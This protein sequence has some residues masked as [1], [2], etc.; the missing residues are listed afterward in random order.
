MVLQWS[1]FF[2]VLHQWLS[3]KGNMPEKYQYLASVTNEQI[4]PEQILPRMVQG[5]SNGP[6]P[7]RGL[8]SV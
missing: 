4:L 5:N 7:I 6:K 3:E 2:L 1:D 8:L